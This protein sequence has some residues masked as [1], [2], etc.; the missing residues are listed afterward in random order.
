MT[1]RVELTESIRQSIIEKCGDGVDFNS[2]VLYQAKG[3]S[4]A[5]ITQPGSIYDKAEF[6]RN[7][8]IELENFS[9]D[10]DMNIGIQTL[11]NTREMPYGRLIQAKLKDE[12]MDSVLYMLFM[13]ST[14]HQDLI[15]KIDNG[16]IDEVSIQAMPKKALCSECGKDF[17]DDDVDFMSFIEG[18]CPECGAIMGL[19]GAHLNIPSVE[20]FRELSLVPRGAA[21]KPKI[22]DSVHQLAMSDNPNIILTKSQV[23]SDLTKVNLI[24]TISE[25]VDMNQ[26][27]LKA[28]ITAATEPLTEEVRKMQA[29]LA[30]LNEEKVNLET[31]KSEAESARS[32]AESA[33]AALEEENKS[34]SDEKAKVEADLEAAKSEYEELKAAFDAEIKKVLVASGMSESAIP[35]DLKEKQELLHKA[36]LTLANIPVGGVS[37][38]ADLNSVVSQNRIQSGELSAYKV[39]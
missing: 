30:T 15:S 7:A 18:R 14:E 3:I 9:N 35:E 24:S 37:R 16:I 10:K 21:N 38:G 26:E 4:T 11:H 22:L 23:K 32:E 25:E 2:I 31:A 28:A 36:H 17:M 13:M 12:E 29:T 39:K 1:K 19:D 5:P 34:L 20:S 33:K 8:L 27:Q 6:S